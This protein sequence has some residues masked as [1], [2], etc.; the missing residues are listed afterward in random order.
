MIHKPGGKHHIVI[1]VAAVAEGVLNL[2][3]ITD[4][5]VA[6]SA[7]NVNPKVMTQPIETIFDQ[8][9]FCGVGSCAGIGH[10][11]CRWRPLSQ[12]CRFSP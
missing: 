9:P 8:N 5:V 10:R 12:Q 1:I 6:L 3:P 2:H 4:S 7:V 11:I